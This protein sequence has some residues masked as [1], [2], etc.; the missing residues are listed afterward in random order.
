[1]TSVRGPRHAARPEPT[2]AIVSPRI[3]TSARRFPFRGEQRTI[4]D[5]DIIIHESGFSVTHALVLGKGN[6]G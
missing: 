3:A 2:A 1:M 6:G 4:R 5:N